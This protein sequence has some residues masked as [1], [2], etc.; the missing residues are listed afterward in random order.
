LIE[1]S[2]ADA[3]WERLPAY[4]EAERTIDGALAV[5]FELSSELTPPLAAGP[6][7]RSA[8]TYC[9]LT[10]RVVFPSMSPASNGAL[11]A[12]ARLAEP[13]APHALDAVAHGARVSLLHADS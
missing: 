13:Y 11:V 1:T 2:I 6:L 9:L 8:L 4:G 3:I 5:V 10:R 7:D 12:W